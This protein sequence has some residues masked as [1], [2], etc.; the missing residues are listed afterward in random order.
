MELFFTREMSH[1]MNAYS[2]ATFTVKLKKNG[3]F[4]GWSITETTAEICM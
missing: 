2:E 1:Y 4:T 3:S